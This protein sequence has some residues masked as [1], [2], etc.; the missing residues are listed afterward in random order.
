M[1]DLAD[2][3]ISYR[4]R[5]PTGLARV[6]VVDLVT[7][8]PNNPR[9]LGFQTERIAN[10]LAALPVLGDDEMAEAQQ[11]QAIR[12]KAI[13]ATADATTLDVDTLGDVESRLVALSDAVARRYFLQGAEPLRAVGLTLA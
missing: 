6:A 12:L 4:Q 2:S 7:L 11:A 9:S 5:Y 3:Q 13:V 1:L 8:D 10:H